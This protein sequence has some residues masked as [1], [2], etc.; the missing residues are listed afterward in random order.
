MKARV[1]SLKKAWK[2]LLMGKRKVCF[3]DEDQLKN[4]VVSSSEGPDGGIRQAMLC[5]AYLQ[6]L[7]QLAVVK[8]DDRPV[9]VS[10]VKMQCLPGKKN[11]NGKPVFVEI[12]LDSL[13][14]LPM[15]EVGVRFPIEEENGSLSR[16]T[17][18]KKN[19]FSHWHRLARFAESDLSGEDSLH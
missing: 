17:G 10:F 5:H 11:G 13:V 14:A 1:C 8:E 18:K 12:P 9:S 3:M 7:K 6:I 2:S 19:G 4:P 15:E 16:E